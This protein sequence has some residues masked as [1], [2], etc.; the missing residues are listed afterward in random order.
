[1]DWPHPVS[2]QQPPNEGALLELL[3]R[4]APD[5]ATRQ[6]ILVDNP[7]RLFGFDSA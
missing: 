7:A 4:F 2:V 3:Y 6:K 1:S 5:A